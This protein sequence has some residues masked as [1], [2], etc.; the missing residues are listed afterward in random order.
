M[1]LHWPIFGSSDMNEFILCD[2][3]HR[4]IVPEFTDQVKRETH[5]DHWRGSYWS[6]SVSRIGRISRGWWPVMRPVSWGFR[7]GRDNQLYSMWRRWTEVVS[8]SRI[9]LHL[10]ALSTFLLPERRNPF[11][12]WNTRDTEPATPNDWFIVRMTTVGGVM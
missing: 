4:H 12:R 1:S 6:R 11:L 9:G 8:Q 10:R 3:M 7:V 2:K 5:N